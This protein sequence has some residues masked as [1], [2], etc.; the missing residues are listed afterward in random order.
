MRSFHPEDNSPDGDSSDGDSP[1]GDS[2]GL[3]DNFPSL[4]LL[5]QIFISLLENKAFAKKNDLFTVLYMIYLLRFT[6][7]ALL[8]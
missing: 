8:E 6:R 4:Y 3:K 1:D 7:V 5:V 2:P